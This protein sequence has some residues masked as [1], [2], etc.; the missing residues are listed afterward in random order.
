[1]ANNYTIDPEQLLEERLGNRASI[2]EGLPQQGAALE[3]ANPQVTAMPN[4][5]ANAQGMASPEQ[6]SYVMN[7]LQ[8]R[9]SPTQNEALPPSPE[10]VGHAV[11]SNPEQAMLQM[12]LHPTI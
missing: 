11:A 9:F 4:A 7:S 3:Q 8:Q 5:A 10:Q 2:I 12:G 1:M 6:I